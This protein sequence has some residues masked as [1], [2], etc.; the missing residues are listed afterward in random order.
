MKLYKIINFKE[1][2]FIKV[3]N[4]FCLG[5]DSLIDYRFFA[6]RETALRCANE[7]KSI[8]KLDNIY[9]AELKCES[10]LYE[11]LIDNYAHYDEY[12]LVSDVGLNEINIYIQKD[13]DIG[14]NIIF[15]SEV[16]NYN[17]NDIRIPLYASE[18]LRN[19]GVN[20]DND[21]FSYID[22]FKS[23]F[24]YSP[25]NLFQGDYYNKKVRQEL[26]RVVVYKD[27]PTFYESIA[28]AVFDNYDKKYK[29]GFEVLHKQGIVP[30]SKI[31]RISTNFGVSIRVDSP[32]V[33]HEYITKLNEQISNIYSWKYGKRAINCYNDPFFRNPANNIT[34]DEFV[35]RETRSKCFLALSNMDLS[36]KL[37]NSQKTNQSK[38]TYYNLYQNSLKCL[39]D[40]YSVN[41]KSAFLKVDDLNDYE[42][43]IG[44]YILCF[45]NESK[46]YIGQTKSSLKKRITQHFTDPHSDFDKTH[47][48]ESISSIYILDT[49]SEYID[50]LEEDCIANIPSEVLF[51]VFAGG[52]SIHM[53]NQKSYSREDHVCNFEFTQMVA[54]EAIEWRKG[55]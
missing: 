3:N 31:K 1:K 19:F 48:F 26:G 41:G 33:E 13:N 4:C 8:N 20:F 6:V 44:I 51:N 32:T 47:N 7:Y 34:L 46:M 39:F 11:S 52:T 49:L 50:D 40:R 28:E 27:S 29:F 15:I 35:K 14:T 54:K 18:G 22:S 43:C 38:T 2:E 5:D 55:N 45:D 23:P 30:V 12:I 25:H 24:N 37:H 36:L 42:N 10:Y 17:N 53:I 16:F 9:I 21:Y